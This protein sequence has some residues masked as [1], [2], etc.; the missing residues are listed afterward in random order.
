MNLR[1][2]VQQKIKDFAMGNEN[3]NIMGNNSG[4]SFD[5]ISKQNIQQVNVVN[6]NNKTR[7]YNQV[8]Y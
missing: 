1:D 6:V 4:S 2:N 3:L 5:S 8:N 7:V